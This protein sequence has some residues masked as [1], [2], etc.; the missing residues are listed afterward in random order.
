MELYQDIPR[1][2]TALAEWGTCVVYLCLMKKTRRNIRFWAASIAALAGQSIW[3][4]MTKNWTTFL[5]IPSMIAAAGIMYFYLLR[6]GQLTYR[7]ALYCCAK[8]FL[9]AEFMASLE[10]Q[11]YTY[12]QASGV[13]FAPVKWMMLIL[14]YGACFFLIARLEKGLLQQDYLRQLT[15]KEVM[16]AVGIVIF[17]FAFSNLSFVYVR[18]PFTSTMKAEIFNI[19]TLVD[20]GGIAILHAYQ[21]KICEFVAEKELAAINS[22]LK[23]QYD[24]YRNY[25]DSLDLIH[26][27]YHDLKHQITGLRMETDAE[28]RKKW[29]D[30][31]E[32]EI[33]VFETMNKTGSQVLDTV[34]AAKAFVCR[35][36]EIQMTCVADGKLLAFMHV[37]D[38]CSIFG[39]A[40]DN[41]IESVIMLPEK[42]KRL[43]HVSVSAK[44]SFVYILVEN[45][46]ENQVI[47]AGQRLPFTTKADSKNHGFGLKSIDYAVEK[48]EGSLNVSQ[49]GS[50]F[51]LE[52]LIPII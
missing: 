41:A 19:R 38:I 9:W 14:V 46:C 40:L 25:Q 11:I 3:L 32:E 17:V 26:M 18:S 16:S 20:M 43:I 15:M 4:V 7:E 47:N 48:Y 5:W 36:N 6:C 1:L 27:K 52:I 13:Y 37:I 49:K 35:K 8:A 42:E 21:S 45:Y 29:L 12:V 51:S 2:Y 31:I 10:W 34:L 50:W 33:S 44:K 24:Q 30:A 39:N 23:S 22:V 28:R